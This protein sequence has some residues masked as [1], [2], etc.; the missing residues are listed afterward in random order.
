MAFAPIRLRVEDP[1]SRRGPFCCGN[2]RGVAPAAQRGRLPK[3][4]PAAGS[5]NNVKP[6]RCGRRHAGRSPGPAGLRP[7][8]P[9]RRT[10][11]GGYSEPK[12]RGY[13]GTRVRGTYPGPPLAT[14]PTHLEV[15]RWAGRS[16][17]DRRGKVVWL[18][19]E[20]R[21]REQLVHRLSRSFSSAAGPPYLTAAA[22]GTAYR[23]LSLGSE[24]WRTRRVCF[25]LFR[26]KYIRVFSESLLYLS[27]RLENGHDPRSQFR[28]FVWKGCIVPLAVQHCRYPSAALAKSP[29]AMGQMIPGK[30]YW[31]IKRGRWL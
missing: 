27:Q 30:D 14:A 5:S 31:A 15:D 22:R 6:R 2:P 4:Q 16:E 12:G 28:I 29:S 26:P 25:E 1:N 20:Y 17:R 13:A 7:D 3:P 23:P 21:V 19:D 11:N 10:I 8:C 24:R 9:I 18:S